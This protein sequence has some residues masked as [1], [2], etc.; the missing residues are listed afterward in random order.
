M[1]KVL[2]TEKTSFQIEVPYKLIKTGKSSQEK[3][4]IVH[5][6]GFNQNIKQFERL[7]DDLLDL[8]AFH[9]FIQ[10]PYPIYNRSRKKKVEEWG[11]SWYLYDGEQDQFVESLERASEFVESIIS[12]IL[13]QITDNRVALFGYSMG[14]YLAGYFALSRPAV[15]SELIVVGGRI[16]TEVFEGREGRYEHLNV[17]A[18]HGKK[19]ASV[20]SEPQQKSCEQLSQWGADVRFKEINGGHTLTSEYLLETK[21]WLKTLS[22][23]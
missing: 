5:L 3:P 23:N 6:H 4:L 9:L 14:G 11:R 19:D 10:G 13:N 21:K 22:Y 20:K 16:K 8:Q 2:L 15:I 7:V 1:K 18:L 17:L 12:K